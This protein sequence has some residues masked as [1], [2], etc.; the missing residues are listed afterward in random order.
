MSD[1]ARITGDRRRGRVHWL[2][3]PAIAVMNRLRYPQKFALISVLFVLPLA[4]VMYLLVS[5]INDRIEFAG[6]ELRGDEY[7][8]PLR[9][10]FEH[11]AQSYVRDDARD[12]RLDRVG[13]RAE[14]EAAFAA[15]AAVEQR[16]GPVLRTSREYGV[17]VADGRALREP[18]A[19]ADRDDLH[20]RLIVDLRALMAH[21]G[22]TSNLILDPDLDSYYLMD[23]VLLK[24]PEATDISRKLRLFGRKVLAPDRPITDVERAD[25]I[26]L[27]SLLRSTLEAIR[28]GMGVAFRNNPAHNLRPRLAAPLEEYVTKTERFLAALDQ[29]IIKAGQV[30]LSVDAY[31][32]LSAQSFAA[33]LA[34]WDRAA[35]QLDGLLHARVDGFTRKKHMVTAFAGLVLILV[36]YLLVAFYSTVMRTVHRLEETTQRMVSGELDATFTLDTRDELGQVANSFNAIAGRLRAEWAQAREESARATAAESQLRDAKEAAEEATQAKSAFLASMSH[37]LRTP[38]NAILGYSDMLREEAEEQ[39]LDGFRDDLLK[40]NAAGS[41]LLSLINSILDLSKI[42]A[43]KMELHLEDFEIAR[44]VQDVAAT[45][46]PLVTKNGNTLEVDCPEMLGTMRADLTKVRQSL[47]NLLSNALKFTEKGTVRLAAARRTEGGS[48]WISFRVRDSGIGMTREQMA[49]LFQPFTQ[50]DAS[51]TK[52]YG[53]TGLG[54]SITKKFCEMMGGDITVE[55]EAGQG[56]EF[57]I[58][59]PSSV[60]DR[61]VGSETVRSDRGSASPSAPLVP[62][63]GATILAIDDDPMARDLVVRS[64]TRGGFRV[65]TA[66]SGDEGLRLAKEVRPAAITLDAVMPGMDGWAVLTALKCDAETADIPVVMLTMVDDQERGYALGVSDYLTKP[67]DRKRL[68]SVLERY[69]H[70]P[71]PPS[72]LVVDDDKEIRAMIARTLQQAGWVVAEAEQGRAGLERLATERP[73]VILLDL[74]MPVMDGFEFVRELRKRDAWRAIPV[75]IITAKD[76]SDDDRR[77]LNGHVEKILQKDAYRRDQL[78]AEVNELVNSCVRPV[79]AGADEGG[80]QAPARRT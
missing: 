49:K 51:T 48:D 58:Q 28:A 68:A 4:L 32:A 71:S 63:A 7:L 79:V 23:A 37:E 25:F 27:A 80:G 16:L 1:P 2:L 33:G 43:G 76:L 75:I 61:A 44:M 52:K 78:L 69:R 34:L 5:E 35:V 56:T 47:L 53:G 19:S 62:A 11:V 36:G 38:M 50:A 30:T 18:P 31:D 39:G 29:R 46:H 60:G 6:K 40:I 13:K 59:L 74:M 22:D 20:N 77:Q 72:L 17:V 9:A 41:H 21:V 65:V 10:L 57:C 12:S 45:V 70:G 15:L 26:R 3:A 64:L 8:R 55:S 73:D 66:S 24:L 67:L 54:L 42:E 14:I